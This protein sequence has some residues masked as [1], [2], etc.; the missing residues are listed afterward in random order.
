MNTLTATKR[1]KSDKL[2]DIRNNGMVPAVVY[3]AQVENTIIYVSN[4]AFEKI[5]KIAGETGTIILEIEDQKLKTKKKFNVLIHEIQVHPVSESLVHID[6]LVV[7]MNKLIEVSVP[8][9][10]EGTAPAEKDGLGVLIKVLHEFEVEALP[11]NIPS[12]IIVDLSP[13]IELD[14]QIHAKNISLPSGVKMLTDEDEVV[15]IIAPIKEEEIEE[16]E[17]APVDL[18]SIEVDKKGKKDEEKDEETEGTK[19]E[20]TTT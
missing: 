12:Q 1:S 17:E 6:F 19:A 15:A 5:Y 8:I 13:L 4:I 3:G 18:S 20:V 9:K 10:F 2:V 16:K 14:F 7:D 11:G